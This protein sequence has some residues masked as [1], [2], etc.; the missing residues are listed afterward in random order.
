[1]TSQIYSIFRTN[2]TTSVVYDV[3]PCSSVHVHRHLTERAVFQGGVSV[4][5]ASYS[6]SQVQVILSGPN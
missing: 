1:M 2:F 4:L 6:A 3:V 5:W